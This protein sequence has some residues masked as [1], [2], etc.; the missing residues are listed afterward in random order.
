MPTYSPAED[1]TEVF[2][3][4]THSMNDSM[5]LAMYM[6]LPSPNYLW[7]V[8]WFGNLVEL[9]LE[10]ALLLEAWG[11]LPLSPLVVLGEGGDWYLVVVVVYV[12]WVVVV[13]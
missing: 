13:L 10:H 7:E 6:V 8:L 4:L 12:G 3:Q 5:W 2:K 11:S 9:G 1:Y